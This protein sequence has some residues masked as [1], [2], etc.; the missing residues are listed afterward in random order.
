MLSLEGHGGRGSGLAITYFRAAR[1]FSSPLS[2]GLGSRQDG[3]A[4]LESKVKSKNS[5]V[6]SGKQ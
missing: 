1:P 4:E 5:K 2:F 3:N 6:K